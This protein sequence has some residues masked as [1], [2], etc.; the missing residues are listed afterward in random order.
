MSQP[1][2]SPLRIVHLEDDL[3][4]Y[5]LVRALLADDGL[6][7]TLEHVDDPLAYRRALAPTAPDLIISDFNLPSIDG[8]TALAIKRELCP[9][10][11]FIFVSGALGEE[12]AVE[13]LRNGA[14]DFVLKSSLARL[15]AAVRRALTET[16]EHR[17]RLRAEQSLRA[18]EERFRR[19]TANAPDAIFRYRFDPIPGYEYI[20]PAIE[21][22][23]GYR[24]EEFYADP[25]LAAR[26]AHPHDRDALRAIARSRIV[27]LGMRE[28]RWIT[29]D[30]H[31]VVTE[32]RFVP[33][34]N[35]LGQLI[36]VEG[37]ARDISDRKHSEE[38]IHLLSEAIEQSPVGVLITDADN[39]ILFANARL[40]A[41]S[42]RHLADLT[43][44]DPSL[45][46]SAHNPTNLN[47]EMWRDLRTG[48]TWQGDFTC[49]RAN[50]ED[51]AVRASIAPVFDKDGRVKNYLSIH[52]DVTE[53][54]H[55]LDRRRLLEAQLFQ[56]Q[57]METIGT[58]AGGIAH[59]FNNILTG[60]LGFTEIASLALPEDHPAHD[61]LAEVRKAGMRAKDLVA[62]ILTFAR[63]KGAQQQPLELTDSVAE[64][65]R[66]VRASAPSTIE[67][68]RDLQ[69]GRVRADPTAI[70]QV[71]LNLCTNAVHAMR[72]GTGKLTVRVAPVV[73]GESP[74]DTNPKLKPGAYLC[75]SIQDTGHGM[76]EATLKRLFEPFFTTKK[77]GEGTGLG[78]ALVRGI[79]SAHNGALRVTSA[80]GVGTTFEILLPVCNDSERKAE[81][82]TLIVPG[83]GESVAV[84]D[85]E[86]S[87]ATF[88]GARLEQLKYRATVFNDPR[89]ALV[90]L[91]AEP[92][93]FD[94]VITDL[95]MPHLTGHDL[96][97]ALRSSALQ[98][99][100]V[101]MSGFCND[102]VTED[103]LGALGHIVLLPKPFNG[104]DLARSVRQALGNGVP[105]PMVK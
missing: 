87:V 65:L 74:P 38:Q 54:R 68:E 78:L 59:D 104:D 64:A 6:N 52:E 11:P 14:T 26:I 97:Q 101:L 63:Q 33:V 45:L 9:S 56:A 27:P 4:A 42:G 13:T 86:K 83:N 67:I 47:S 40:L 12:T 93:R 41:M 89:E 53:A 100:V 35:E 77:V 80:P 17:E 62:Q 79:V 88:V 39:R 57:K 46:L 51:Y 48:R 66:L 71:V 43:G 92:A 28:I 98:I 1:S 34:R 50:G 103:G 7:A 95:T 16:R 75:L 36:A 31:T 2:A 72:G 58:L 69:S 70:H 3:G 30:G 105:L 84:V 85:D 21:Q 23:V 94:L 96:V 76:D 19:L 10:I 102:G 18:S 22:I 37:I 25:E 49:Q 90:A 29:R 91:R 44:Q 32:Q 60:I 81:T 24:P 82:T 55:D 8:L 20:S 61:D 73:F 15:P 99:P 5:E